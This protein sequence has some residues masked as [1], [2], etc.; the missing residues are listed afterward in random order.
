M[1]NVKNF[2]APGLA[3]GELFWLFLNTQLARKVIPD[4]WLHDDELRKD[5]GLKKRKKHFNTLNE[6]FWLGRWKFVSP[7]SVKRDHHIPGMKG[8]VDWHATVKS[9]CATDPD[10]HLNIE[11]KNLV[12]SLRYL[13]GADPDAEQFV[14]EGIRGTD[15]KFPDDSGKDLNILCITV[16]MMDRTMISPLA[17]EILKLHA[18]VDAIV[19]WQAHGPPLENF[20][21]VWRNTDDSKEKK[22]LLIESLFKPPGPEHVWPLPAAVPLW[23]ILP[24][25]QT[26]SL[27]G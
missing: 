26:N 1:F 11:V 10:L 14:K 3:Y 8:N 13:V 24:W 2:D 7:C 27:N 17:E 5:I 20:C 6:I 4:M 25:Q 18:G 9:V 23:D 21:R 16:Y 12:S 15:S 19:F 22:G